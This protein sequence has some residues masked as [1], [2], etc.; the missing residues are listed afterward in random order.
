MRHHDNNRK[1]GRERKVRT[2]LMRSLAR[3]FILEE[4]MI[5]TEAK[6]KSLRPMVEKLITHAKTDSVQKRRFVYARLG[7]DD[8]ATQKLFTEIAPRYKERAGGYV[9]IVKVGVRSGD[10]S[11]QAFIGLV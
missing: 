1:F 6:A 5:T 7:N 4:K 11:V 9:R 10:A 2:A 8:R 3:N